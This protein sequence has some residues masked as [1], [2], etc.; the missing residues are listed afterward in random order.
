MSDIQ[1]ALAAIQQNLKANKGQYNSFGKYKYRNCEDILEA[2][3]PL[4][5]QC[6]L[7]ISDDIHMIGDRFYVKATA[8][9]SLGA[10]SISTSAFAREE[11][12][13]K[14]MDSAQ[15]TGSTSAYARKYALG[16]LLLTDD[17]KDADT[18]AQ[19]AGP[20]YQDLENHIIKTGFTVEGVCSSYNVK[21]LN[22]LTDIQAVINQV[23]AWSNNK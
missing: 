14:G 15:L 3:K 12:S 2:V 19:S 1:S 9:I 8:T 23:T 4:L 6:V 20:S 13:K 22:Q 5:G 17:N 10:D 7:T 18:P 11:L 16:G 21:S